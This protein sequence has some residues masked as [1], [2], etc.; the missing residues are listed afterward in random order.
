MAKKEWKNKL[1]YGDNL[2]VMRKMP[3]EYV[4]LIYL[5]PPFNSKACYNVIFKPANGS[6]SDAQ[7]MAFDDTWHFDETTGEIYQE[8]IDRG[9]GKI[10]EL[11]GTLRDFLGDNDLMAYLVMMAVR[12]IE[13]YRIL[14]P[15]GSIYLHCDPTA[16]HYIKLLMDAVFGY[17]CFQNEVIWYYSGGG[18]SKQRWARKHDVILYYSKSSKWYF[19]ID[20]V[21][22]PYKWTDGQKR[23]D[24]SERDYEK[25]KIPDDVWELHGIMPWAG[26]R[27]GYPTQK[28][29]A[30]LERIIN[31][32]CP[33]NGTVLDP[34]CGCG[35]T[36]AV[37]ERLERKWVGI[38]V[39]H[40][41]VSLMVHRLEDTFGDNLKTYEVIGVPV[42]IAGAQ[43]L[44]SEDMQQFKFWSLS[45][46]GARPAGDKKNGS[47]RD[48]VI[49]FYDDGTKKAKQ[50]V[51][52]VETGQP[53]K[54]DVQDLANSGD[55]GVLITI[56]KPSKE[57]I[58]E[59]KNSG[60]YQAKNKSGAPLYDAVPKVQ[61]LT[62]DGL[63]KG[64]E[65]IKYHKMK[66][67]TFQKATRS[68]QEIEEEGLF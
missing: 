43:K 54:K 21:R 22:T 26:E 51:L 19:N 23:A 48:G 55:I 45:L 44:A 14:K 58:Q 2:D 30:L 6:G 13:M 59:A 49:E 65:K 53:T 25:G 61:I 7:I 37:A 68:K 11:M 41:A 64:E 8:L 40:L 16:S 42:D 28:P 5:D 17:K 63:L 10:P 66:E 36:V 35:T 12:M 27:L 15:T 50:I 60:T 67:A 52:T 1:I 29:E 3:D 34:F 39:T 56:E 4:D 62:I 18:A 47:D 31:A 32:S 33:K 46:V 57:V 9:I 24:G 38:D 20:E